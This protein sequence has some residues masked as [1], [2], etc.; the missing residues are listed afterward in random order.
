MRF[1]L[2]VVY[3]LGDFAYVTYI[4]EVDGVKYYPGRFWTLRMRVR[5]L[6][7]LPTLPEHRSWKKTSTCVRPDDSICGEDIG[8]V[9]S[10][11]DL[12]SQPPESMMNL[13][14]PDGVIVTVPKKLREFNRR[15]LMMMA[16]RDV[17]RQTKKRSVI[18]FDRHGQFTKECTTTLMKTFPSI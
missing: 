1:G 6:D 18:E 4:R 11:L 5:T 15:S 2:V 13:A 8:A 12:P 7:D 9:T 16:L 17:D 3:L 14:L 10:M